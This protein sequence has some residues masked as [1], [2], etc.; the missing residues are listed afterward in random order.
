MLSRAW[1]SVPRGVTEEVLSYDWTIAL[2]TSVPTR[3]LHGR[4]RS[5]H[6]QL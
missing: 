2:T 6:L 3:H 1:S 4:R 5:I